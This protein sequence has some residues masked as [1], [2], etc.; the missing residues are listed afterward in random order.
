M[1]EFAK[2]VIFGLIYVILIIASTIYD[3]RLF[4]WL[5]LIFMLF[6]IYEFKKIKIIKSNIHY[7]LGVL[8]Y[9]FANLSDEISNPD[10]NFKR[11]L[12][13][14]ILLIFMPF[15]TSLFSKNKKIKNELSNYFLLF[16]YVIL[17]FCILLQIP[18]LYDAVTYD[19]TIVLSIFILIWTNDTFAFLVGSKLGKHKLFERISPKKTIEGFVGGFIFTL[20]AGFLISKF[21]FPDIGLIHLI[22]FSIIVSIFGTIGDLVE[23]MFKREANVKDSSNLI[24]GHGGFLDRLDSFIFAIPF[25]FIYLI[26]FY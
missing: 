26:L 18:Y 19:R 13:L 5:F 1:G 16:I 10:L 14:I 23:S 8:C 17:P 6:C 7:L 22:A 24:P 21:L 12:S 3:I 15:I 2:R 9:Y 20:L 25:I 4:F 11:A